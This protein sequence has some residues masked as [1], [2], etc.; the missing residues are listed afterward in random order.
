MH[1]NQARKHNGIQP[2]I[3]EQIRS[4]VRKPVSKIKLKNKTAKSYQSKP[5]H[6]W[7]S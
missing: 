5:E 3:F 7:L 1:G 6:Q 4:A 2:M